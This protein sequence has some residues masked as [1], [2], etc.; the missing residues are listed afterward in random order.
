LND[1]GTET[2]D[3]TAPTAAPYDGL[4]FYEDPSDVNPLTFNNANNSILEGV[5]Y[6]PSANVTINADT[7][8]TLYESIDA[9]SVTLNGPGTLQDYAS[10]NNSTVLTAAQLVE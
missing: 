4:L 6:A 2:W 1:A 7:T 9:A 3:I 5:I 10:I 8:T